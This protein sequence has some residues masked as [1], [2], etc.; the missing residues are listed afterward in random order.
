[1]AETAAFR[2]PSGL[3]LYALLEQ[4]AGQ[5][6]QLHRETEPPAYGPDMEAGPASPQRRRQAPEGWISSF[7]ELDDISGKL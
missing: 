4:L 1:L 6:Y 2:A 7:C 5:T 3:V